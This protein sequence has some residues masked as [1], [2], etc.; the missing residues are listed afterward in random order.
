MFIKVL[1]CILILACYVILCIQI[2]LE[3]KLYYG[4][5]YEAEKLRYERACKGEAMNKEEAI[6]ILDEQHLTWTLKKAE[7]YCME[8]NEALDMAIEALKEEPKSKVIA[9][10]NVDADEIVKLI[11]QNCNWKQPKG[12][13]II[14]HIETAP[15]FVE[16]LFCCSECGKGQV[17]GMPNYCPSCGADMRK[18][19][20]D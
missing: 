7:A 8:V 20:D 17:Y 5:I 18:V 4:A 15:K 11:E 14:K 9:Q 1:C 19:E 10:I 12:H 2:R 6:K 13:W 16:A 3:D